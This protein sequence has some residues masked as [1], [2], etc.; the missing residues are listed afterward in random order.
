MEIGVIVADIHIRYKEPVKW[1]VPIKVGARTVK[2]GTKSL[3]MEQC[4]A[5]DSGTRIYAS[6][7]VVLVAYDYLSTK[8]CDSGCMAT[9]YRKNSRAASR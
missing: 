3:T 7:T 1:G 5:D 4:V 9:A 8:P 2:L 6:G